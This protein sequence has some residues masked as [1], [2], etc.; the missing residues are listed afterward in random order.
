[1]PHAVGMAT[2]RLRPPRDGD[3]RAARAAQTALQADGFDFGLWSDEPW[4]DYL[5]RLERERL[6]RDLQPGRVP[7]TYLYAAVDGE[8][9]GRTSV[10]HT[11][12]DALVR[13]GGHIGYAV[14]PSFRRRGYATEILRQSLVVARAAGVDRVL[15]TCDDDNLGS[16][17]VIERCGGRLDPDRSVA[18]PNTRRY[19][20]D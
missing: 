1:V 2:L 18:E 4:P 10:R 17:A 3:E 6:G 11:L 20:I 8:I 9:V 12:N 19:W 14:L 13:F 16:I 7:A 15:V 5:A